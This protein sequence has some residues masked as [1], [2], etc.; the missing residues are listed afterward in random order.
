MSRSYKAF[1]LIELLVVISII[2]ILAA[3]LFPVFAQAKLAAKKI[4]SLSNEKQIGTAMLMYSN[5]Y[6]DCYPLSTYWPNGP[7][8]GYMARWSSQEVLGPYIKNVP[9]F[10]NAIDKYTI[11]IT[12]YPSEAPLPTKRMAGPVSFM[13]NS[14]SNTTVYGYTPPGGGS[15]AADAVTSSTSCP[16]FPT[17]PTPV[18][19]CTGA[20]NPGGF[21]LASPSPPTTTQAE[22]PSDLIVLTE[23]SPE[24]AAWYGCPNTVNTETFAQPCIGEDGIYYGWDALNMALGTSFGNSDPNMSKAWRGYA[25]QSNFTFSDSHAKTMPPGKLTIGMLLN[26]RYWLVNIPEGY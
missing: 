21:Y 6:D 23:G 22:S 20:I 25:N 3:I 7:S 8:S 10:L 11:D 24:L 4:V 26:P 12:T 14:L 15:P 18:T 19:D 13:T 1:T 5:D 2:A 16:F 17:V 9:I